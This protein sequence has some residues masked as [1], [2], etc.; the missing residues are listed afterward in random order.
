MAQK[1]NVTLS[2]T[3][4]TSQA[5][6]QVKLLQNE[7]KKLSETGGGKSG[8]MLGLTKE[9]NDAIGK[10]NELRAVLNKA[11]DATT[12]KIDLSRFNQALAKSGTSLKQYR[13]SLLALGPQGQKAFTQLATSIANA[14][15]KILKAHSAVK[16]MMTTLVNTVRW[17]VAASAI[18]TFTG[19]IQAALGY[20]QDLDQSL[21]RIRIVSGQSA[22]QMADF[23]AQANKAAQALSTTTTAYTD[24]AL[25]FFQMGLSGEEVTKR[26]E[27]V[28]KMAQVTGDAVEEVSSYMTAVWN[29]FDNGS[30]SLEYYAD[31]IAQLGAKTAASS[32]EISQGLEKFAAVA[33][34]AG[35]SYEYATSALATV[36]ATTRQS[37]DTVGTAFK[38]LFA[39]IQDLELGKTLDDGTTLGKYSQALESVGVNIKDVNGDLKNM[40]TIL[41]ELGA[42]WETLGNDVQVAVA[43]AIGGTRQYNQLMSLMENWD[44]MKQ[45]VEYAREAEGT[46]QRQ[47]DIYAESWEAAQ[48]RIKAASQEIYNSLIDEKFFIS[49]DDT[50]TKLLKGTAGLIQNL[51]GVQGVISTLATFILSKF[52]GEIATGI[53]N[54]IIKFKDAKQDAD[55]IRTNAV[56]LATEGLRQAGTK[57]SDKIEYEALKDRLNLQLQFIQNSKNMNEIEQSTVRYGLDNLTVL[58]DK[59]VEQQ[60]IVEEKQEELEL[61]L[62]IAKSN[63]STAI[64]DQGHGYADKKYEELENKIKQYHILREKLEES[65]H[66]YYKVEGKDSLYSAQQIE[67]YATNINKQEKNIWKEALE[68]VQTDKHQYE[69]LKK[70]IKD[71]IEDFNFLEKAIKDPKQTVEQLFNTLTEGMQKVAKINI[72]KKD[73]LGLPDAFKPDNLNQVKEIF[74][75][76]REMSDEAINKEFGTDVAE[77]IRQIIN[78]LDSSDPNKFE[79]LAK[80]IKGFQSGT[81]MTTDTNVNS[82]VETFEHNMELL[83]AKAPDIA[84]YVS[85]IKAATTAEEQSIIVQQAREK[86]IKAIKEEIKQYGNEVAT[87]GQKVATSAQALS[88]LSMA[89]N[90]ISGSMKTLSSKDASGLQ[91]FSAAIMLATTSLR[92]IQAVQKANNV[93]SQVDIGLIAKKTKATIAE[94]VANFSLAGSLKAVGTAMSSLLHSATILTTVLLV[95]TAVTEGLKNAAINAADAKIELANKSIEAS[96]KNK[97]EIASQRELY[98]TYKEA[99]NAYQT[100]GQGKRALI[101]AAGKAAEAYQIEDAAVAILTDDYKKLSDALK[102]VDNA[103]LQQSIDEEQNIQNQLANKAQA[104]SEKQSAEGTWISWLLNKGDVIGGIFGGKYQRQAEADLAAENINAQF[105]GRDIAHLDERGKAV[106]TLQGSATDMI[107][108][109]EAILNQ[110]DSTLVNGLADLEDIYEKLKDSVKSALS[111]QAT[112]IANNTENIDNYEAY[113]KAIKEEEEKLVE[114][115]GE[116]AK[117]ALSSALYS[118]ANSSFEALRQAFSDHKNWEEIYN[119]MNKEI[120]DTSSFISFMNLFP[121]ADLNEAQQKWDEYKDA[122]EEAQKG[123]EIQLKFT[124]AE[125]ALDLIKEKM[126]D[127]DWEKFTEE[128]IGLGWSEEFRKTFKEAFT[129]EEQKQF[130]EN[131]KDNLGANLSQAIAMQ[132]EGTQ[133][134]IQQLQKDLEG[135]TQERATAIKKSITDYSNALVTL[136]NEYNRAI[137]QEYNEFKET[138]NNY[139]EEI[140]KL[141]D[142]DTVSIELVTYLKEIGIENLEKYLSYMG[143]G[144]YKLVQAAEEFV[145]VTKQ[146]ISKKELSSALDNNTNLQNIISS[147]NLAKENGPAY[148]TY[149]IKNN[150]YEELNKEYGLAIAANN[151]LLEQYNKDLLEKDWS[152]SLKN[153]K[154]QYDKYFEKATKEVLNN[155]DATAEAKTAVFNTLDA[156]EAALGT[157]ERNDEVAQLYNTNKL[158][159][160]YALEKKRFI[161]PDT[162]ISE[163]NNSELVEAEQVIR[164]MATNYGIID[165]KIED[166]IPKL[167]EQVELEQRGA[168]ENFANSFT[169][170]T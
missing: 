52:N 63:A 162:E 81:F 158:N 41:D 102:E 167:Q 45:N 36:V 165:E 120:G 129:F 32:S 67:N 51:G 74:D 20:V 141:K 28:I 65:G 139:K 152:E 76:Y 29:N 126:S 119:A 27:T 19:S 121:D 148:K 31:V 115:Y 86:L 92:A 16:S 71:I 34:T 58:K 153:A 35:L 170:L 8:T 66:K 77:N 109:Y 13:D 53:D 147:Y 70:S 166:I 24:A 6:A 79:Q 83:G 10:V 9:V 75:K 5:K 132:I 33:E 149:T 12:G 159:A 138:I 44:V 163:L 73:V 57:E 142:G 135:S 117:E 56:N 169:N 155:P 46:V 80:A 50:I 85:Q 161:N 154:E 21:N 62:K 108:Q 111:Q 1:L 133:K 7:L 91:K 96:E 128:T 48:K 40:D 60:K 107:K 61:S 47:A 30:K 98:K 114:Q 84:N 2:L 160:A 130:L 168:F 22:Q 49:V 95:V 143:D 23:A 18:H 134:I 11:T 15:A 90:T 25:I 145:N 14:D 123:H 88:S 110:G 125:N 59:A 122:F 164:N 43:Q 82:I 42:R 78:V 38:T 156:M 131:V 89:L 99:L 37:A 105:N 87:T 127:S 124:A 55:S 17:Q 137:K 113:S 26:T 39:R 151:N 69:E 144:T 157:L 112:L 3:A 104:V 64:D 97:E 116:S 101:E 146:A 54:L 72:F 150:A 118:S 68:Q 93:L 4:D 100:T 94:T 103:K 106:I 140:D 136:Q